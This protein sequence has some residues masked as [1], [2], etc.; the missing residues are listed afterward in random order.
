[1][2]GYKLESVK[3]Y[4]TIENSRYHRSYRDYC[5]TTQTKLFSAGYK[6]YIKLSIHLI[7]QRM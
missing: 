7:N 4:N 3:G 2:K 6:I 5:E 1:M